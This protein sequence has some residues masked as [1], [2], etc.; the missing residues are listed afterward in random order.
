MSGAL[1]PAATGAPPRFSFFLSHS[2]S[3]KAVVEELK[4]RLEQR[5]GVRCWID[6]EQMA[7]GAWLFDAI[8][9]GIDESA[10]FMAFVSDTYLASDNCG[11]EFSLAVDWKKP[12]VAINLVQGRWPPKG[13]TAMGLTGKLYLD[14]KH[15]ITDTAIDDMIKGFGLMRGGAGGSASGLAGGG[16][17]GGAGS[18]A[19]GV[20]GGGASGGA[21]GGA[22]ATPTY[23]TSAPAPAAAPAAAAAVLRPP[24][25]AAAAAAATLAH[26]APGVMP[27][28]WYAPSLPPCTWRVEPRFATWEVD[29]KRFE[30][31]RLLGK[32]SYGAVAEATD[33]LTG[34]RVAIKRID[35]VFDSFEV[36]KRIFREVCILRSMEHVNVAKILHVE[37]PRDL[38]SF[39]AIYIVFECMDTDFQKLTKDETQCLTL[40]HVRHFLYQML[41]GMS[42]LHSARI[43]HRDIKPANLLVTEACDL[44]IYDFGLAR[45]MDAELEGTEAED[46]HDSE[47]DLLGVANPSPRE[48]AEMVA[49][50]S[51]GDGG[52]VGGGTSD[53]ADPTEKRMARIMTKHVVTRWYRAPELMLYNDGVYSEAIDTWAA[54]CVFAEMLGMID[55]GDEGQKYDRKA[56]FPGGAYYPLSRDRGGARKDGKEKKDQLLVILDVLGTP[57]ED[58]LRRLRSDEA[59]AYIRGLHPHARAPEDLNRRFPNTGPEAIDLLRRFLRLLPEDRISLQDALRHPFLQSVREPAQE[60]GRASGAIIV[61]KATPASIR[62]LLVDEIRHFNP[63]IV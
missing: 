13:K 52:S 34:G 3:N 15:E 63:H 54:G 33:H 57:S 16:A 18:S 31:K 56:L 1:S 23:A 32:G 48:M 58:E 12:M 2:W 21:G 9:E 22:T 39:N 24:A 49:V 40:Q 50:V 28:P 7:A 55:T 29:H 59:R 46:P 47:R 11:M 14:G 4:R 26:T 45:S 51:S 60:L 25:A 43:L 19:S 62:N 61:R 53:A 42:Y 20:A 5:P 35:N 41:C 36:A 17:S 30:L 27:L 38:L 37:A 8:Q 10:V 6:T 44:K